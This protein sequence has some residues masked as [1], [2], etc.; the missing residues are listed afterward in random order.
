M[1]QQL[2]LG[3]SCWIFVPPEF[4]F[5][6]FVGLQQVSPDGK[7][8]DYYWF[9]METDKNV[10]LPGHW[11]LTASREERLAHVK[12]AVGSIEPK[13]REII[14]ATP[15]SSIKDIPFIYRDAEL[16]SLPSGNI[17]LLGDAVHPMTPC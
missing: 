3:H 14:D 1:E 9:Y 16:T 8:G 4:G 7:S 12:K 10:G 13:F 11:L 6:L 5:N 2:N 17:A 15:V